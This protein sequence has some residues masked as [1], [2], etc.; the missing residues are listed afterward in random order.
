MDVLVI[1]RD[2]P[3][4]V[5]IASYFPVAVILFVISTFVIIHRLSVIGDSLVYW[6]IIYI[7][8]YSG[9]AWLLPFTR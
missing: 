9:Y 5:N 4:E 2:I 8:E 1:T 7:G 6:D 3:K